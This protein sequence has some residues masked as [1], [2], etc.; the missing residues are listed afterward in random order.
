[1]ALKIKKQE[2]Y[3]D[4]LLVDADFRSLQMCL[5]M[6][7]EGLNTNGIDKV[8]Y[9]IYQDEAMTLR[10]SGV[11]L[12][13]IDWSKMKMGNNDAHSVTATNVFIKPTG[14]MVID[15]VDNDTGEKFSFGEDQ[16]IKIKRNGQDMEIKGKEFKEDDIFV[17]K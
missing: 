6:A 1:M 15:I 3:S 2:K 5:A 10:S 4:Y 16:T 9:D 11:E 13:D 14:K 7:D 8:S 12:K 17:G